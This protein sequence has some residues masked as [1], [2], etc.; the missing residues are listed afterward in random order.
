MGLLH[1]PTSKNSEGVWKL[2][3]RRYV[4]FYLVEFVQCIDDTNYQQ[5]FSGHMEDALLIQLRG[6]TDKAMRDAQLLEDAMAGAGTKD[7]LLVSRVIR[8]HWDRSHLQ[9][10]KGAY[11]HRFHKDLGA[12]I[13]G[14]TSG[15]YERLM[16]ACIGE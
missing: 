11:R 12:R 3:S 14:E 13:R 2:L 9:Q 1:V 6:G 4:S 8:V 7:E 5:E 15:D 16:L 10:V